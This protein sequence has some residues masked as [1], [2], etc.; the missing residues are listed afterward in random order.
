MQ[1]KSFAVAAGLIA[2]GLSDSAAF[3]FFPNPHVTKETIVAQCLPDLHPESG[4]PCVA[5]FYMSLNTS[6]I[7]E[8]FQALPWEGTII[9]YA[10]V[11]RFVVNEPYPQNADHKS[12]GPV[13]CT[14]S[15]IHV[16][17]VGHIKVAH[18]C[19]KFECA[20]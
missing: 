20:L 12:I 3:A 4:S 9:E 18:P 5:P 2:V 1:I 6:Q 15:D 14:E 10:R 7:D 13:T 11:P 8:V 16:C 17:F 19:Y